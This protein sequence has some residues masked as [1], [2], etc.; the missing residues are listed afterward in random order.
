MGVRVGDIWA[1]VLRAVVGLVEAALGGDKAAQ[2]RLASILPAE[3]QTKLVSEAQDR[4]DRA[5][6]GDRKT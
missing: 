4:L 1:E 5:K 3:L 6:F 2:V